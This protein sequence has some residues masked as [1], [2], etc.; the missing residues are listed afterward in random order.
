[1]LAIGL[2]AG[3]G[4]TPTPPVGAPCAREALA[5]PAGYDDVSLYAS[6]PTGRYQIG[7]SHEPDADAHLIRWQDGAVEDMGVAPL[8]PQGINQDGEIVGVV[9]TPDGWAGRRL[10]DGQ[11]TEL[12]SP[13]PGWLATP[14]AINRAGEVAGTIR[15]APWARYGRIVVWSADDVVHELEKPAGYDEATATDIA[16]DGTVVGVVTKIDY[17]NA[18]ITERR[19]IVWAPDGTWQ[20]LPG[21]EPD[22]LTTTAQIRDGRIV[23]FDQTAQVALSWD[24]ATG[25]MTQLMSASSVVATN[26]AGSVGLTTDAGLELLRQGARRPLPLGDDPIFGGSITAVADGDVVYGGY[27]TAQG[28]VPARWNC[29]S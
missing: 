5:L 14:A 24:A 23:G 15:E 28:N 29:Q 17:E 4:C 16:E 7:M 13:E 22:S 11:M 19:A 9:S 10:R 8:T 1:M 18:V 6:D 3:A 12:P 21:I 2:L 25:E 20:F 27:G 26:D